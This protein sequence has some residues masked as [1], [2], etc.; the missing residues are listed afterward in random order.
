MYTWYGTMMHKARHAT[1][2]RSNHPDNIAAHR[3]P[4]VPCEQRMN[5]L[6]EVAP[7]YFLR[8]H[9]YKAR[10]AQYLTRNF[11]RR[12]FAQPDLNASPE[13]CQAP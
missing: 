4:G 2:R 1:V 7:Y 11:R 3:L 6:V 12:L 8:Q 13:A 5:A 10:T 9:P